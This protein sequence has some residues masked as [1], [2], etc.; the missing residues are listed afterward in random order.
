[1]DNEVFEFYSVLDY[2][3]GLN[4]VRN[5]QQFALL[6]KANNLVELIKKEYHVK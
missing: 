6:A 3:K 4:M 1:M 2:F 5:I